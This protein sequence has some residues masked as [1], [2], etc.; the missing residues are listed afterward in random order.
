MAL[1][2]Q[3]YSDIKLITETGFLLFMHEDLDILKCGR[4][5]L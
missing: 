1:Q 3:L 4:M 5:L 2:S